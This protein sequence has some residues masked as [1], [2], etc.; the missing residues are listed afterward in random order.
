MTASSS[1][2]TAAY[3]LVLAQQYQERA[4]TCGSPSPVGRRSRAGC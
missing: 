2:E 1:N 4:D 3:G